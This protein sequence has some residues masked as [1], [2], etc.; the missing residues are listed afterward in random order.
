MKLQIFEENDNH[1]PISIVEEFLQ[2][3]FLW[4]LTLA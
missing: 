3:I 4:V 2:E 1:V